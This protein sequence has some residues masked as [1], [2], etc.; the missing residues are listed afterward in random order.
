MKRTFH[1][2]L[3]SLSL[4][5][6]TSAFAIDT[7]C[8]GYANEAYRKNYTENFVRTYGH[9]PQDDDELCNATFGR[10]WGGKPTP[11]PYSLN[12]DIDSVKI[13]EDLH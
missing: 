6:A 4:L 11:T 7:M 8:N 5:S 10:A 9:D 1:L 12:N 3:L 2:L 13:P